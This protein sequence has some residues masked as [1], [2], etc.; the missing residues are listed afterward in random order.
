MGNADLRADVKSIEQTAAEIRA[1]WKAD[2]CRPCNHESV[3]WD[4][5]RVGGADSGD[6]ACSNCG[7]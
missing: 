3:I 4:R 7:A 5:M 1:Q 2:G 6:R